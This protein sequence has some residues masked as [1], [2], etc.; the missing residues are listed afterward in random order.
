VKGNNKQSTSR[1]HYSA[2]AGCEIEDATQPPLVASKPINSSMSGAQPVLTRLVKPNNSEMHHDHHNISGS[3][4]NNK[5]TSLR[6]REVILSRISIYI[7]FVFL[8]C[9]SVRIIPNAYEMISTY[10]KVRTRSYT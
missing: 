4:D 9:H 8:F 10:T 7:V 5:A 6:K 1:V 3:N 2:R